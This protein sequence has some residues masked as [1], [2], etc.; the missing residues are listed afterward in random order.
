MRLLLDSHILLW[1]VFEPT[2]L[3]TSLQKE[4]ENKNNIVSVSIVSLWEIAVKQNIGRLSLPKNFFEKV[5]KES[6]FDM[7]LLQPA[8]I[9]QYLTLPLHHRDPFDRMLIAQAQQEELTLVTHD[10]LIL[11]Y[12]NVSILK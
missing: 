8:H 5:Q 6:G 7:L 12:E 10:D 11:Q 4:I 3:S 2:K 1:S 9:Q